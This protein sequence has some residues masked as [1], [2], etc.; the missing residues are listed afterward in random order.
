VGERDGR[1]GSRQPCI[2]GLENRLP[3]KV[4]GPAGGDNPAICCSFEQDGFSPG[5][6]AVRE[7]TQCGRILRWEAL[8]QRVKAL[9]EVI[10]VEG[11]K[12]EGKEPSCPSRARNHLMYGPGRPPRALKQSAESSVIHGPPTFKNKPSER[13][14]T[15]YYSRDKPGPQPVCTSRGPR[16]AS[17]PAFLGLL[18]EINN[19]VFHEMGRGKSTY[20]QSFGTRSPQA[21]LL[22]GWRGLRAAYSHSRLRRLETL[23]NFESGRDGRVRHVLK[24]LEGIAEM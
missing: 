9:W 22:R 23:F 14:A 4:F 12:G 10:S 6:G 15:S 17:C 7:C 21:R 24:G 2:L 1:L 5:P 13:N 11:N 3:A 8:K 18:I 20:D 16:L 19:W